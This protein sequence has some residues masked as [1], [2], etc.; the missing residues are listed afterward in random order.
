MVEE[1]VTMSTEPLPSPDDIIT[2]VHH[3]DLEYSNP[4]RQI[5]HPR[6]ANGRVVWSIPCGPVAIDPA[7]TAVADEYIIVYSLPAGG[8]PE[9]VTGQ[10][11]IYDTAPGDT[12]YSPIWR[13]NYVIVPRDYRPQALRS[14]QDVLAS[15]YPIVATDVYTN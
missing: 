3:G 11:T 9:K 5:V 13:H 10:Y 15:G 2:P 6:W 1:V 4:H 14:K 12:G 8:E 7:R